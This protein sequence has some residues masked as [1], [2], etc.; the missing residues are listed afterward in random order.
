MI[1]FS[2]E[3]WMIGIFVKI[4]KFVLMLHVRPQNNQYFLG[5]KEVPREQL[6]KTRIPPYRVDC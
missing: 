5:I 4:G 3:I 2:F 1:L 6:I